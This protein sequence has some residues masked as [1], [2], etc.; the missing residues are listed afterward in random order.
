MSLAQFISEALSTYRCQTLVSGHPVV[1]GM[2]S[3]GSHPCLRLKKWV[4]RK[5]TSARWSALLKRE[6]ADGSLDVH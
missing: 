4:A 6:G 2:A 5:G 3:M 1:L